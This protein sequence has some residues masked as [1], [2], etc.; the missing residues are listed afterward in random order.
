M[1]NTITHGPLIRFCLSPLIFMMDRAYQGVIVGIGVLIVYPFLSLCADFLKKKIHSADTFYITSFFGVLGG[2]LYILSIGMIDWGLYKDLAFIF[3]ASMTA[4]VMLI[5]WLEDHEFDQEPAPF[6]EAFISSILIVLFSCF[7]EWMLY[8]VLDF[9][10]GPF[11]EIYTFGRT[12][13]ELSIYG[14]WLSPLKLRA[15]MFMMIGLL[16]CGIKPYGDKKS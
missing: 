4:S 3:P 13:A 9:R 2:S 12:P 16:I 14:A 15:L 1:N 8:G 10:F 7:R 5:A 11:G 6:V